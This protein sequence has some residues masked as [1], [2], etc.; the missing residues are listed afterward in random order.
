M[1][2]A[3]PANSLAA[4]FQGCAL[5]ARRRTRRG[6]LPVSMQFFHQLIARFKAWRWRRQQPPLLI[7]LH[8]HLASF[9]PAIHRDVT[10]NGVRVYSLCGC[11]GARLGASATLCDECAQKRSG[12]TRP[13]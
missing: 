3:L 1:R 8:M 7:P 2:R 11:C 10:P 13:Y 4:G 9:S 6:P 5:P 12:Q